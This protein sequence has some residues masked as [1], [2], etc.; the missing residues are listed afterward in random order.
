[1]FPRGMSRLALVIVG[2][3]LLLAQCPI[4]WAQQKVDALGDP[5]PAGAFA[6]I[7]TA[8]LKCIDGSSLALSSGGVHLAVLKQDGSAAVCD[9]KTGQERFLIR[10]IDERIYAVAIPADGR[11]VVAASNLAIQFLDLET[12]KVVRKLPASTNG[13]RFALSPDGKSYAYATSTDNSIRICSAHQIRWQ[14]HSYLVG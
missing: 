2:I 12:G 14:R 13:Y 8:R 11:T 10:G 1:M 6:R 5:L 9:L 7:G 3:T 4:A